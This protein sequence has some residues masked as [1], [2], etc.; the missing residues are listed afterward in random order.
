MEN[1]PSVVSEKRHNNLHPKRIL[2]FVLTLTMSPLIGGSS[3][4]NP[5]RDK[6][7]STEQLVQMSKDSA[8]KLDNITGQYTY[9]YCTAV[10]VAPEKYVSAGHCFAYAS[11]SF[12]SI[13]M[14]SHTI[15]S[16][17][18]VAESAVKNIYY[19]SHGQDIALIETNNPNSSRITPVSKQGKLNPGETLWVS[20][21]PAIAKG[22]SEYKVKYLGNLLVPTK[23]RNDQKMEAF[24]LASKKPSASEETFCQGGGMSGA[25]FIN[26]DGKVVGILSR[27]FETKAISNW[28]NIDNSLPY[29][30]NSSDPLVCLATPVNQFTI[31]HI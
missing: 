12:R 8:F 1:Y 9:N 29:H 30:F 4:Q 10:H 17:N 20:G 21:Y 11:H 16:S 22:E 19:N 7:Q 15:Y 24:E 6:P 27:S 25:G 26:Q 5:D 3:H 23:H 2:P 31:S 28:Q 14:S 13:P 18:G